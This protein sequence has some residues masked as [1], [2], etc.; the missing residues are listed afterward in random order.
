[1]EEQ[2][3]IE[4]KDNFFVRVTQSIRKIL[5]RRKA[6]TLLL[7]D[8]E[9]SGVNES[10]IKL[11]QDDTDSAQIEIINARKA[12]RKYVINN[13]K[14]I[15]LDILYYIKDAIQ[16]NGL[17]IRKLIRINNGNVTYGDIISSL[18][19]EIKS[20]Q[21]FKQ[22]NNDTK[23]FNMP[24]GVIGV[25]CADSKTSIENIFKAVST[26]NAV[27]ILHEDYSEFSTEALI[28]MI[29]KETLKKFSVS[30]NLVQMY[31]KMEIDEEQL[32]QII[33]I[34][35]KIIDKSKGKI[36]Y[37]YQEDE[38]CY[39]NVIN[40]IE[41]LKNDEK[42][43]EY[44]I[45]G[46][47]G[48]FGNIISYLDKNESSAICMYTKN[49]QKAYKFINWANSSNIFVNTGVHIVENANGIID[50]Y[51]NKKFILHKDVF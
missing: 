46:I 18:D 6:K 7:E 30:E 38:Q 42:Y 5:F 51:Y 14:N 41:R 17:K 50:Q 29:V 12:Y 16:K 1:M 3:I 4:V 36:I 25:E 24:I 23:R 43:K 21:E 28:L 15:S 22:I 26:R 19:N 47:T 49:S 2:G 39:Y 40:E 33:G 27:I 48:D 20:V 45:Q 13:T 8:G 32:N 11:I 34:D 31:D 10:K 35:G 9:Q 44:K 37:V